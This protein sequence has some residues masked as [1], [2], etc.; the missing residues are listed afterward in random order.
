MLPFFTAHVVVDEHRRLTLAKA[1]RGA[2]TN[3]T[4]PL[5]YASSVEMVFRAVLIVGIKPDRVAHAAHRP[6]GENEQDQ[7]L[8]PRMGRLAVSCLGAGI[9]R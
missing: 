9:D 5:T 7:R 8:P 4:W 2:S 6:A 1:T 3:V